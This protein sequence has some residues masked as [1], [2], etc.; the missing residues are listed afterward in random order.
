MAQ[1]TGP[2]LAAAALVAGNA[3]IVQNQDPRTQT[4][5]AVGA[6]VVAAG[7]AVAE[8][9]FPT[10]AVAFA[11]VVLGT[12]VLVRT[13]PAVPSPAESFAAWFEGNVK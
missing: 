13:N 1:S 4:K 12:V 2:I 11:W 5:V 7:L 3:I 10:A 8:K 9:A 6:L